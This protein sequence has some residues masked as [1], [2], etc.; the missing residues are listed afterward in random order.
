MKEVSEL[1]A[2]LKDKAKLVAMLAPSFPIAYKYPAIVG[3]LKRLGFAAVVEVTAGAQRTN[4]MLLEAMQKD[5]KA[6]FI[7]SP[8]P[9]F[10][11]FIRKKYPQMEKYLAYS[12][13]SPMV[14]SAKIVH[15]KW[16]GYRPVFIGPCTVKKMEASEDHPDLN[17]LVLTYK[18]MD[19]VLK[20]FQITEDTKDSSASFDISNEETRLYPISG[21]LAQSS[22][23][24]GLLAEDE[25]AVVSGWENCTRAVEDFE[26]NTRVRLLDILFCDGGCINNPS[27]YSENLPLEE[28]RKR[29]ID[30][31]SK[32]H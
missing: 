8:C 6:R 15:E 1:E 29:I 17:I 30:Y 5:P 31:W 3:K 28:R 21:G 11:R 18:E 23:V 14:A 19:E 25:L 10:V 16:P 13:D 4:E 27:G 32:K 26:K 20:S 9:S 2:L 22:N 7:T 24:R 12:V